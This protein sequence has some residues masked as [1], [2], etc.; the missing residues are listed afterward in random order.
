AEGVPPMS[1]AYRLW[2]ALALFLA[3]VPAAAR[4]LLWQDDRPPAVDPAQA[5]AGEVLFKHEWKPKDSLC[6]DGDGLRPL[7]HARSCVACHA[8][9]GPAGGGGREHNVTTFTVRLPGQ[10]PREGVVHAHHVAGA[11]RQ[12]TVHDVHAELPALARPTLDQLVN[13]PG[14]A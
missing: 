2:Y 4:L 10:R 9:A 6:P 7:C 13:L 11:S 14:R 12:E 1:R 3:L 5:R 8:Q